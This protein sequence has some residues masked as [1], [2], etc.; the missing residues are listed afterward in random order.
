[1]MI[2]G[3]GRLMD[4]LHLMQV[5]VA[6]AEEQGFAAGARKL[7]L[8]PPAVTRAIAA[9]EDKLK[10]KLLNR[11][12]RYVRTTESGERYLVDARRILYEVQMANEAAVGIN[13]NPRGRLAITAPV[14]FGKMFVMPAIVEYLQLYPDTEIE[15]VFLDRVVNLLEEG[16]DVGI[17]IGQ[18]P[19]SSLRALKVGSVRHILCASPQYIERKGAPQNPNELI[20]HDCIFSRAVNSNSEWHFNHNNQSQKIR[21]K[22]RLMVNTNDA[23]IESAKLGYGITRLLSYQVAPL[24]ASG[25]LELLLGEYESAPSPINVVHREGHLASTKVRAFIDLIARQLIS[26]KT[27]T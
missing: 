8:S 18:L 3:R 2:E 10:V 24:L 16:L 21:L 13:A 7:G 19:D 22:P 27:L 20:K 12:T 17:R 25:E 15:A 9:L 11:T 1:M 6:V 5:Y 23:A 26:D 4:Q 14:L